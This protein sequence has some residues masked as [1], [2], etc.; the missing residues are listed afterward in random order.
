MPVHVLQCRLSSYISETGSYSEHYKSQAELGPSGLLFLTYAAPRIP[1]IGNGQGVILFHGQW[2]EGEMAKCNSN[3]IDMQDTCT[4]AT[5]RQHFYV[6]HYVV[7]T[8][9]AHKMND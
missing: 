9:T 7:H 4:A 1:Y 5:I 2:R 3:I 8:C 6:C